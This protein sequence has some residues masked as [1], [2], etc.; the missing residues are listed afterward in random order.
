MALRN[1]QVAGDDPNVGGAFGPVVGVLCLD[2]DRDARIAS[3]K[4]NLRA[5]R[6]G[7]DCCGEDRNDERDR[8]QSLR[9][10]AQWLLRA[11]R[12]P[13]FRCEE[14]QDQKSIPNDRACDSMDQPARENMISKTRAVQG[15]GRDGESLF[16]ASDG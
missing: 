4:L 8:A 15:P 10:A 1:V 12:R 5:G 16:L 9:G 14:F 3:G 13:H 6:S 11:A 2:D 7:A